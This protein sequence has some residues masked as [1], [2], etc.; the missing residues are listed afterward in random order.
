[1]G[2]QKAGKLE[3]AQIDRYSMNNRRLNSSNWEIEIGVKD[4]VGTRPSSD[5]DF[6]R[7]R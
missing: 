5:Y 3:R 2:K 4:G 7:N 1:M 6:D